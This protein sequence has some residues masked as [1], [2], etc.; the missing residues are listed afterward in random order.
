MR[1]MMFFILAAAF[2]LVV[3]GCGQDNAS[4]A[5]GKQ[6]TLT[7]KHELGETKVKKKPEK[8]VVFDFGVLDTL[9][10]WGVKVTGLPQ[11]NLPKYLSKFKGDK[12]ENVGSLKEP[13]FEKIHAAQPDLIII[14]GRQAD[15]YDQFKEIAPTIYMGV[16]TSRYMD[17]FR[18][19]VNQLA[20]IF[21][22]ESEAKKELEAIDK[23]IDKLKEKANDAGKNA[24]II[25]AND[26][27]VSAYGTGSRF[28][29]IH[30]VFGIKPVD[31]NIKAS[32]HGQSVSF[33]YIVKKDPDYLFVVDRGAVVGGQS[34]AKQVVENDLV[35]GTKAY[36]EKHIIY[37]DP[38]YWYL[39]GGGLV[40]LNEMVKQVDQALK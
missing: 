16:D 13:D 28:G 9:D 32:T 34:S 10:Q 6:D 20:K 11:D 29:L 18:E 5:A 36:K 33:E 24:L 14:S 8:V 39:S 12:Y 37:L 2:A 25:L 23:D 22:K 19:N 3:A 30:D 17:S 27:K 15:M 7:V 35:K 26:G 40:S 38:D 21:D 1:K 4:P 31:K